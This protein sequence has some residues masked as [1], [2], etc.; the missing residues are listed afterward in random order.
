MLRSLYDL[1]FIVILMGMAALVMF[2]PA[3]H[4]LAIDDHPTSR[5]F[6]YSGLLFVALSGM[7]ALAT[8]NFRIRR[9]GRSHLISILAFFAVL[10]VMLAVP[11]TEAVQDTS[12]RNAYVE[13]VSSLTTTGMTLFEPDR[14]PPSVHLWRAL[15]GWLGGFFL[16]VTAVA[17]LAP[18]NLGGFE[19][20]S[21]AEIGQGAA[22][23]TQQIDRVADVSERL[24]RFTLSLA[25]IYGGLTLFLA[26]AL[27][28]LG[29]VPLVAVC[30]AMATLSTSGISPVGG[31]QSANVSVMG[32]IMI[33]IFFV[34]ALSRLTFSADERA[35]GWTSLG[36]D[37]ELRFGALIIVSL[38]LL[39]FLRHWAATFEDGA[40]ITLSEGLR[41]LWGAVFT[42]TS[43]L[44]T[45]GFESVHWSSAQ[46]WSGFSSPGVLLLGL[47]VFGG[48]VATTA[49]GVKL[50]R[51]YALYKHGM[52]EM[53]KLVQPS[54]IG[55]AGQFA[56]RFRRQGAYVA[57][58]FFMLFALSIAVV[59]SGLSLTGSLDFEEAMIVT[60]SA[61]STTGPLVELAG[62]SP[63]DLT[64]LGSGAWAI[65][66]GAMILG[67][68]ETL[69]IIALLNPD[70]WR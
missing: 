14:L 22:V 68:L 64:R 46:A 47:A 56:R 39:L 48:G 6:F 69:A 31:M 2:V 3:T 55:G 42:V 60:I 11:F 17:V 63:V 19:V 26:V 54:S 30:H 16:W 61:L 43:F 1:P 28:F 29:E 41:G 4:A 52:R 20:S 33:L 49:G 10:P 7:V 34:F 44:T 50:L 67:R 36:R 51:V 27:M 9:Q 32:E 62:D 5:A 40:E 24:R 35:D 12:F 23:G 58:I 70:F 53:E 65:V 8:A 66:T 38:S 59:M 25:P 57:W 45:T 37:P 18:L 13:M 21:P 15:V